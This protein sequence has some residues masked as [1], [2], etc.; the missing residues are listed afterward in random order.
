MDIRNKPQMGFGHMTLISIYHPE[1][2]K[3]VR[4]LRNTAK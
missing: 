2:A 4:E 1:A 3:M